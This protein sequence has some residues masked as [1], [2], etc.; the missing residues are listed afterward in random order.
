MDNLKHLCF[1]KDGILIDVHAYWKH[2]TEIRARHL[3]SYFKLSEDQE[4]KLIN[5]MGISL[6]SGKIKNE[7]P[8][9]YEPR[10]IIVKKVLNQLLTF[11]VK[12]TTFDIENIFKSIDEYQQKNNDYKIILLDGVIEFLEKNK[13]K[14]CMTIFTSD[15]T[16]NAKQTLV[17]LGIDSYFSE[18]L[19]GDSI[20]LSKPNPEGIIKAC[21]KVHIKENQTAY[22]SDTASDL[23]MAM[24]ANVYL[25][26]GILSG[27]GNKEELVESGDYV[28]KNFFELINYL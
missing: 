10:E 19:G 28:C 6:S 1:D 16:K 18:V 14:Y 26:I 24:R 20:N 23:I 5:A 4:S 2:T 12:A 21:Q 8:V 25:K 13:K 27:L 17:S 9:G 11:S 3:R 15:R 7:G 22:I